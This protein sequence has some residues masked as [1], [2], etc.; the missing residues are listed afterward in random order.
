MGGD[1]LRET[2]SCSGCSHRSHRCQGTCSI[3]DQHDVL[4]VQVGE[5]SQAHLSIFNDSISNFVLAFL[6]TN[7]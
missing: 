1:L 3:L 6:Q 7:Q 5:D 4:Y 2:V